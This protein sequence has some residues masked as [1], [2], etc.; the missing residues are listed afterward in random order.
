MVPDSI[1][2]STWS[3]TGAMHW[4]LEHCT[5][6][7]SFLKYEPKNVMCVGYTR[8]RSGICINFQYALFL[9]IRI[10]LLLS[11]DCFPF[12]SSSSPLSFA[13]L[14]QIALMCFRQ[15]F[16]ASSLVLHH[17]E[18]NVTQSRFQY[19]CVLGII[20]SAASSRCDHHAQHSCSPFFFTLSTSNSVFV[21]S[22]RNVFPFERKWWLEGELGLVDSCSRLRPTPA[23]LLP[24]QY[25][26]GN[27]RIDRG[28]TFHRE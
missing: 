21:W 23:Y 18:T 22:T 5:H 24:T 19:E 25:A 11:S 4:R 2:L 28:K 10:R 13:G 6:T 8:K 20:H 9:S 15:R 7:Y 12:C 14:W 3:S 1:G 27:S 26:K 17:I 16:F